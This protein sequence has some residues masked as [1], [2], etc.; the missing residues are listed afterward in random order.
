MDNDEIIGELTNIEEQNANENEPD[1]EKNFSSQK[2]SC[3][4]HCLAIC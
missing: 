1:K 4:T 2:T 3:P